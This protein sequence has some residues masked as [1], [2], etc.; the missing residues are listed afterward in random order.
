[1]SRVY[2]EWYYKVSHPLIIPS[3]SVYP[4]N[5]IGPSLVVRLLDDILPTPR[6][7]GMIEWQVADDNASFW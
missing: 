2:L 5:I 1:M 6:P 4:S 3:S 7:F